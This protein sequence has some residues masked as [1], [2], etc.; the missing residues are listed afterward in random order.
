MEV[1][2]KTRKVKKNKTSRRDALKLGLT[3]GGSA[4][5]APTAARAQLCAPDGIPPDLIVRPS[6]PT[7]PF[8]VPLPIPPIKQPIPESQLSPPPNP[9]N[10]QRYNEFPPVKF[11]EIHQTQFLHEYHPEMPLAVTWGYDG[12]APGPT[13]H[14]RDGEP[15]FVR[16]HNDLP[17]DIPSFGIPS[18][19]THLHN[20]HTA[21]ESDGFPL[22]FIDP[23]EFHDHHYPNF[24]AGFDERERMTSLWYHDH[25]M[26]FTAPNVYA[27]FTGFLFMFDEKDSGD[28]NDTNPAAWRLPSGDH[29]IPLMIHDILF[30]GDGQAV[31]DVFNTDGILGDKMTINRVVQPILEVE[32]RKYRFRIQNGG[33]SRFYDLWLDSGQPFVVLSNDGNL[34]PRPLIRKSLQLSVAQRNDVIID[35]S[36]YK[37]GDEVILYNRLEQFH[38]RGPTGRLLTPGDAMMKFKVVPRKG[39]DRSRIP[40]HFRPL[41]PIRMSEVAQERLWVFD[42]DGGLWTVNE[43]P[44]DMHVINAEIK[45]GTAEIWTIRNDGNDWSHPIHI[46]FEEFQFLEFNGKPILP[47]DVRYSRKDVVTLGPDDE[48]KLYFRFRDFTGRYIM[49]CHN[50]VHEDHAMMIR[51][52]IV[53]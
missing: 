42:Y 44:A 1:K 9:A 16:H 28:E 49:H 35:F 26:D 8:I 30:D 52:D 14:V 29:D 32:R 41:P 36:R 19:T 21:S 5:M 3:L 38:G 12:M 53:P 39:P 45:R 22:D 2:L 7:T 34:L 43:Q 33:P 48:C 25:R 37:P 24:P 6:P 46:H 15:I 13:F 40:S 27:G 47:H 51:W 11:Y 50:V 18:T 20:Q 17:P 23:G 4:L 10:H 31:F